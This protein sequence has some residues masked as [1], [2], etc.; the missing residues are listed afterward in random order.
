MELISSK[1]ISAIPAIKP[2][3][4]SGKNTMQNISEVRD[5]STVGTIETIKPTKKQKRKKTGKKSKTKKKWK[6]RSIDF[7]TGN[8]TFGEECRQNEFISNLT[9]GF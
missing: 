4:L 9:R 6:G 1:P 5:F 2:T 7:G 8:L 3:V